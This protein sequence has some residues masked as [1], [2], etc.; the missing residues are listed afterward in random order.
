MY[1]YTPPQFPFIRRESQGVANSPLE[2][3][4][5]MDTSTE[6]FQQYFSPLQRFKKTTSQTRCVEI[7]VVFVYPSHSLNLMLVNW[8]S[9]ALC[10][11]MQM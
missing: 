6:S 10:V 11:Q 3:Y 2:Q 8:E 7:S 4:L 9:P 1:T 5:D